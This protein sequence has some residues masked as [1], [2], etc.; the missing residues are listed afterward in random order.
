MISAN[1]RRQPK[2]CASLGKQIANP[3]A[4]DRLSREMPQVTLKTGITDAEGREE[5]LT[6]Y[7]CDWPGCSEVAVHVVGVVKELKMVAVVCA[8]HA[9]M[10]RPGTPPNSIPR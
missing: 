5:T 9:A 2:P 8:Q 3:L 6:E 1:S 7:L 4:R 10:I